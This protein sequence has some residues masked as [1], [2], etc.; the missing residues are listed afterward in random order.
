MGHPRYTANEIVTRG[1]AIYEEQL[2]ARLEP[3]HVGKFLRIDIETADFE[4]DS[5]EFV[6]S[7]RAHEKHPDGAFFGMRVGYRSSGTMGSSMKRAQ[8]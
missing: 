4:M 1:Q 2:R 3:E 7:R 5:D 6:A 8:R